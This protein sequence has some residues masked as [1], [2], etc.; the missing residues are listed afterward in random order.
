MYAS[1]LGHEEGDAGPTT[2][3]EPIEFLEGV[4]ELLQLLL[5]I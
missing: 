4:R 2:G 3:M 5:D 1:L